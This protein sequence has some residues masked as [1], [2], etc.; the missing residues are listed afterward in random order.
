MRF[1]EVRAI[2]IGV[3]LAVIEVAF[4]NLVFFPRVAERAVEVIGTSLV[5]LA[6]GGGGLLAWVL[7]PKARDGESEKRGGQ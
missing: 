1:R 2:A 3:V 5:G 6:I 4:L 7:W